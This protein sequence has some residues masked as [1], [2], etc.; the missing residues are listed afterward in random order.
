MSSIESP[1]MNRRVE[2][3]L[4]A[5]GWAVW[6]SRFVGMTSTIDL[7]QM[8]RTDEYQSPKSAATGSG[9]PTTGAI[10][11]RVRYAECDPMNVAHHA[12]YAPW[13]EIGRTELLRAGGKSYAALEQAGVF[14]VVTKLE[15]KYRRPIV[16]DDVIEVRTTA[17]ES[18]RIKIRHTYEL[19]LIQRLDSDPD[20]STDRRVPIDGVCAVASTELACVN[21]EGR[22]VPLPEWLVPGA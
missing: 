15:I 14:L 13:L 10:S 7:V 11:V 8:N 19:V 16:Y 2:T 9:I 22:P 4:C 21:S 3:G 1:V 6:M 5:I 12:S 17:H 20:P 18:G